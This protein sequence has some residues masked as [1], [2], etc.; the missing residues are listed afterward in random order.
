MIEDS[1]SSTGQKTVFVIGADDYNMNLM[2]RAPGAGQWNLVP[3]LTREDVQPPSGR[4]D[5]EVLYRKARHMIDDYGK[6]PDAIVGYLDF[7]VTSLVSLLTRRYGLPGATPESVACCEHK[8]WM[9]LV[10]ARALPDRTPKFTAINPFKPDGA[11]QDAPPF[12]FWVKPVKGH[13]SV[14]GFLVRDKKDLENALHACRQKIHYFGVPF[15][16]FLTHLDDVSE[17]NGTD[18][19]FVIAEALISAPRQFTLEAYMLKG[20][21]TVYGAIDSV[22]SGMYSSSFSSYQY[23]AQLPEEIIEEASQL[24]GT[25]LEEIGFDNSAFNVE[26]F[27]DPACDALHLLEINPRISKSHGPLFH[28]VDGATNHKVSID[29]S[30]GNQPSMPRREG[31]D[32]VASKFMLRSFEADGIVR[33]VPA[34]EDLDEL[35]HILPAMEANI[36]V[37][38]NTQLSSLFYQDSYS[39][40]LAEIF[41][42]GRNEQIIE[43]AYMRCC[44]SLAFHI[45]P[46][47]KRST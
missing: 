15:N 24:T 33:R 25:L 1:H 10:Q 39:F 7:P 27:W 38:T 22:R 46:M 23:P 11:L 40:E 28:M 41:L 29:L 13:S 14:L 20:E 18:G 26:F 32:A 12:P 30:L 5:F 31:K 42:G 47:P 3:V 19:N 16:D 35:S 17:V 4:I 36:L 21:V 9:R 44:D 45:Q 2:R 8:Y 34:R 6:T 43:D 37:E